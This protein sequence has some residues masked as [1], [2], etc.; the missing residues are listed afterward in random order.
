M[1]PSAQQ[2]PSTSPVF[3]DHG[4]MPRSEGGRPCVRNTHSQ[5]PTAQSPGVSLHFPPGATASSTPSPAA[6]ALHPSLIQRWRGPWGR[7]GGR[8]GARAWLAAAVTPGHLGA[9]QGPA[10]RA[11]RSASRPPSLQPGLPQGCSPER[12]GALLRTRRRG[13]VK[14]PAEGSPP[15]HPPTPVAS[16][17]QA[18][19]PLWRDVLSP[20]E[21]TDSSPLP[22]WRWTEHSQAVAELVLAGDE[23]SGLRGAPRRMGTQG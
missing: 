22:G 9:V 20:L 14:Q 12:A 21:V 19:S 11:L 6:R 13:S 2:P 23:G 15:L 16:P 8:H 17:P 5:P 3:R 4:P 10:G 1:G 7:A 18:S